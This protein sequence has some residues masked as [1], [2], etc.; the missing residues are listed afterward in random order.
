MRFAGV[1]GICPA[2]WLNLQTLPDRVLDAL[3]YRF[4]YPA[5]NQDH[6]RETAFPA[7][8]KSRIEQCLTQFGDF[9]VIGF[10]SIL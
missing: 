8:V 2:L 7:Q 6:D 10:L 9:G 5:P 1:V 3:A 4:Q